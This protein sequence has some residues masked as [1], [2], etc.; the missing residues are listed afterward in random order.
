MRIVRQKKNAT[1]KMKSWLLAFRNSYT[2]N[3]DF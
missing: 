3:V 2:R 1:V